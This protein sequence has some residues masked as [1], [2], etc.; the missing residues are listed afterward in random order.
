MSQNRNRRRVI[1]AAAAITAFGAVV[2]SAA[3]LGG[4]TGATLGADTTVVAS[5]DINGVNLAY[6]TAFSAG[7]YRVTGVTVSNIDA[8]CATNAIKV[9]LADASNASLGEATGTVGG[10]SQALTFGSP[11]VA[12]SVENAAV[13]ISG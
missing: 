12:A 2:A 11:V 13:V 10:T 6:T 7:Q 4:I 8:S 5:C 1:A 3:T 9:T